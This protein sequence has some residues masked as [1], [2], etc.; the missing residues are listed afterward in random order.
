VTDSETPL[1]ADS[2]YRTHVHQVGRWAARLGGPALDL[3]DTVHD[4]FAIGGAESR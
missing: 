3:E 4:V 1:G 2:L